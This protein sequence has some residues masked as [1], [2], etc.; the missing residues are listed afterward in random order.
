MADWDKRIPEIKALLVAKFDRLDVPYK[1]VNGKSI[2][3]AILIPKSISSIGKPAPILV[4]IH[5]G[6]LVMGTNPE[7]GFLARWW[8]AHPSLAL[9]LLL[10]RDEFAG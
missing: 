10:M 1:H 3:T 5:G 6:G 7:P 4:D 8:A 9:D 2:D